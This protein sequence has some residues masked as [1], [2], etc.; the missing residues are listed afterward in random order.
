ML[1]ALLNKTIFNETYA[2]RARVWQTKW[3]TETVTIRTWTDL[4]EKLGYEITEIKGRSG[5]SD[6]QF[7]QS[8]SEVSKC[9]LK[10]ATEYLDRAGC[11]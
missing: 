4:D 9:R 11:Y 5:Q 3:K 8:E 7:P 1:A 6:E 10:N 2:R